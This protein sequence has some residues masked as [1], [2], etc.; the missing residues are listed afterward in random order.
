MRA[1]YWLL[2]AVT[3]EVT[4]TLSL[5]AALG[6][7]GWY[8]V[9]VVGYLLS[10]FFLSRALVAGMAIG[11][12][13]G[14]WGALGVASTAIASALLFDEALTPLMGFGI[15]LVISGVLVV[16]VGAARAVKEAR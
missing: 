7:P 8:G 15:A 16:E 13:Y 3:S 9:V 11:V 2:A 6:H 5:K 10:F 4:A 14:I 12:A 1:W